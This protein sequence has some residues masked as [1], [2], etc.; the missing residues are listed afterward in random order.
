[1]SDV[2]RIPARCRPPWRRL[3]DKM[4][5]DFERDIP[6]SECFALL[7]DEWD[8][9][10]GGAG[11]IPDD[12]PFYEVLPRPGPTMDDLHARIDRLER[13]AFWRNLEDNPPPAGSVP[14]LPSFEWLEE[15]AE[16]FPHL[17]GPDADKD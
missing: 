14:I 13:I 12:A 9:R 8:R 3:V 7:V 17:Y 16:K 4:C 11:V 1:M 15:A 2:I 5:A 10:H 6:E